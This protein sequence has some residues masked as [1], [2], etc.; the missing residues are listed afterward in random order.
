MIF[1]HRTAAYRKLL[2]AALALI[3][4]AASFATTAAP[5][6]AANGPFYSA[7]LTRPTPVTAADEG[8]PEAPA[9]KPR[10]RRPR[11]TETTDGEA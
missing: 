1:A 7:T 9:R 8:A 3:G 2:P 10:T 5:V 4:A 6:R 11:A